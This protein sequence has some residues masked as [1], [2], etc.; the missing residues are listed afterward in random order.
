MSTIQNSFP[1]SG[2]TLIT[3]EKWF[4]VRNTGKPLE[5]SNIN[6]LADQIDSAWEPLATKLWL[7]TLQIP[8]LHVPPL[9]LAVILLTSSTDATTLAEME[10]QLLEVLLTSDKPLCI[11]SL[12][13]DGSILEQAH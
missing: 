2:P 7:W 1:H 4:L 13:S 10:Q 12:G 11:V 6:E 3:A 8:L 9:I 5:V